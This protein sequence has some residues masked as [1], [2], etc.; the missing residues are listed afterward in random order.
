MIFAEFSM[1]YLISDI[2]T[3]GGVASGTSAISVLR[4]LVKTSKQ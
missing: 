3:E 4:Y 1:L 2:L